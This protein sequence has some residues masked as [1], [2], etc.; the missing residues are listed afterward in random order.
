MWSDRAGKLTNLNFDLIK[1]VTFSILG[2][3]IFIGTKFFSSDF[4]T[5][6]VFS[7]LNDSKATQTDDHAHN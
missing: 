1:K 6:D 7:M 3:L 2:F 5:S 4:T